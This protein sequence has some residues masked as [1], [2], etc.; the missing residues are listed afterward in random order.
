[1]RKNIVWILAKAPQLAR[2]FRD[3]YIDREIERRAAINNNNNN[4]KNKNNKNNNKNNNNNN[5]NN[6]HKNNNNNNNIDRYRETL[7]G[8]SH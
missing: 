8:R 2:N 1:M 7:G 4:N 3:R 5:S 6:N